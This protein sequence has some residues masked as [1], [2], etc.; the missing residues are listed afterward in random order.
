MTPSLQ[1][2]QAQAPAIN[3]SISG[4]GPLAKSSIPALQTL[5]NVAQR[6]ETVF[7][8]INGVAQQLLSL[9]KPLL[10]LATNIA[11]LATSFD[12]AGGIEDVMRFIYYYTGSVNGEDAVGHYLRSLVTIQGCQRTYTPTSGCQST[13]WGTT[14][15]RN[16]P[17]TPR[18]ATDQAG[19]PS[20]ATKVASTASRA[21]KASV[22]DQTLIRKLVTSASMSQSATGS[23]KA[24]LDYLLRP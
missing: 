19:T 7:P 2:L 6:G 15:G 11:A 14:L 1:A 23:A 8:R 13:F 12:N 3:A 9:G 17:P 16:P 18:A 10:P 24:L 5:G 22:Q 4:L 21:T 20:T